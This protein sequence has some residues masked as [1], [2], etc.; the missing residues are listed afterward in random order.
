MEGWACC[1]LVLEWMSRGSGMV[2]DEELSRL[3]GE[4]AGGSRASLR[5]LFDRMSGYLLAVCLRRLGRRDLA[6]E[7][8]Q[9]ASSRS[10]LSG[11]RVVSRSSIWMW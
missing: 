11:S 10:S 7:A 1:R 6:E 4:V 3:I 9:A 2:E 5:A 8:R